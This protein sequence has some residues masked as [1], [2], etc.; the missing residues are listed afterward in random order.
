MLGIGFVVNT[1]STND[2]LC[3]N[4]ILYTITTSGATTFLISELLA[5]VYNKSVT[6]RTDN[7]FLRLYRKFYSTFLICLHKWL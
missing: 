7:G 2:S 4:N 3:I 1:L 5:D 6:L